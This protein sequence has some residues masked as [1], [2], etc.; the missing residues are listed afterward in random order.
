[1][2]QNLFVIIAIDVQTRNVNMILFRREEDQTKLLERVNASFENCRISWMVLVN[3]NRAND[4]EQKRSETS[5]ELTMKLAAPQSY[6]SSPLFNKI[7]G[8]TR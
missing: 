4:D 7:L 6:T 1:M 2:V 5:M 8:M 3:L